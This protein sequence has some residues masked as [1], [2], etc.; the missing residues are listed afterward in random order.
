MVV[1]FHPTGER[2]ELPSD[3]AEHL[4]ETFGWQDAPE[5]LWE[6]WRR[7]G[8]VMSGNDLTPAADDFYRETP[9]RHEVHVD[10]RV[11]YVPCALDALSA[12]AM[13]AGDATARSVDPATGAP[14][15]VEFDDAVDVT[16]GG[17][18]ISIGSAPAPDLP[19]L[20]P[21]DS[22]IECA[23]DLDDDVFVENFCAFGNAF[24]S[25]ESYARWEAEADGE[26]F[27]AGAEEVATL[28][29]AL[30]R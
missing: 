3:F 10:G 20:D 15:T 6:W 5:T 27:P 18:V 21:Y 16:P 7:E 23:V 25:E 19:D 14:V 12:A 26:T 4:A 8:E 28:L 13:E 22:M 30:H 29:H 17:A 1:D 11:R 9:T 2:I 24:E